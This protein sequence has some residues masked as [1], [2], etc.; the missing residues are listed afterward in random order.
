MAIVDVIERPYGWA[1]EYQT[2]SSVESG[3]INDAIVGNPPLLV[4][5]EDGKF[6]SLVG[7]FDTT[8]VS[9]R[10]YEESRLR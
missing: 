10:K 9:L 8:E 5:R 4:L 2:R 3:D 6:V 7:T 1:Y